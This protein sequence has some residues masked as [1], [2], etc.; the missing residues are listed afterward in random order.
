MSELKPCPF[1]G[2][3]ARHCSQEEHD[4]IDFEE[5]YEHPDLMCCSNELSMDGVGCHASCQWFTP[6]EWNTR[7]TE[8]ALMQ[9]IKELEAKL[10]ALI[11]ERCG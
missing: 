2:K 7:P 8:D 10:A 3:P 4:N 9:R 6:E 11:A 5:G 1:C